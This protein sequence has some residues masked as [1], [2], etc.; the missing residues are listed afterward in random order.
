[1]II[2][3]RLEVDLKWN[4]RASTKINQKIGDDIDAWAFSG[5]ADELADLVLRGERTA[6]ASVYEALWV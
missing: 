3:E 6:T 2:I 4:W 5:L 1:M